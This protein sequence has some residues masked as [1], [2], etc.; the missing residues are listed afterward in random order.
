[1]YVKS[2]TDYVVLVYI[3]LVE[4]WCNIRQLLQCDVYGVVGLEM[5]DN[6]NGSV[7]VVCILCPDS[8]SVRTSQMNSIV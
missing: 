6:R 7:Y 3:F 8:S 4:T 2:S 1:M 5:V